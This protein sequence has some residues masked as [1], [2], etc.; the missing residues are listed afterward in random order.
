MIAVE[1]IQTL[2]CQFAKSIIRNGKGKVTLLNFAN[3]LTGGFFGFFSLSTY[4]IQH[5]FICRPSDSTL[6]EDAEIEPRTVA[7]SALAVSP[8]ILNIIAVAQRRVHPGARPRFESG[9]YTLRQGRANR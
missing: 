7:T 3:V 9:T 4:C 1:T 5:C 6:S 2:V 8:S